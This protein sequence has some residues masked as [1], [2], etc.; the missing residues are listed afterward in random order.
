M[1]V[2]VDS[3]YAHAGTRGTHGILQNKLSFLLLRKVNGVLVTDSST[4]ELGLSRCPCRRCALS[5]QKVHP[6]TQC[7]QQC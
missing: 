2:A 6:H 4:M 7:S 3:I 5:I 1:L